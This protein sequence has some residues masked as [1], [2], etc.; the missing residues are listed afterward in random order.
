MREVE[1]DHVVVVSLPP[2]A[3]VVV[4]VL[5]GELTRILEDLGQLVQGLKD[6]S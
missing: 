1:L 6:A 3:L 4:P 5:E 2:E